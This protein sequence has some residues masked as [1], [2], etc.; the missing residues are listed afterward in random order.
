MINGKPN[1]VPDYSG[2]T[3]SLNIA[4]LNF[5]VEE[6][7]GAYFVKVL[8]EDGFSISVSSK[9]GIIKFPE[10]RWKSLLANSKELEY[11][12][13]VRREGEWKQF[14]SFSNSVSKSQVDPFLYYRLLYPGAES[15]T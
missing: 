8:A 12:V 3:I 2:I 6:E 9:N 11:R 14:E 10:K 7:G 4:P 1:I 5:L 15:W 13:F